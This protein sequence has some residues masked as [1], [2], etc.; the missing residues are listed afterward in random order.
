MADGKTQADFRAMLLGAKPKPEPVANAGAQTHEEAMAAAGGDAAK[1]TG[2]VLPKKLPA[3]AAAAQR[4]SEYG[5]RVKTNNR[6]LVETGEQKKARKEAKR[7]DADSFELL[8]GKEETLQRVAAFVSEQSRGA[9]DLRCA[10]A[11]DVVSISAH[12]QGFELTDSAE[13]LKWKLKLVVSESGIFSAEEVKSGVKHGD[14]SLVRAGYDGGFERK[15]MWEFYDQLKGE[16]CRTNRKW[17]RIQ[18]RGA[19]IAAGRGGGGAAAAAPAAS[20][21]A[22]G[23]AAPTAS[24][25]SVAAAAAEPIDLSQFDSEEQLLFKG[26]GAAA[27]KAELSRLGLKCGGAPAERAARCDPPYP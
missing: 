9:A 6:R 8:A 5:A 21:G 19:Q 20:G 17:R 27:L 2:L 1:I 25:G 23:G 24:A 15:P 13:G 26:P 16:V 18:Q 10:R 4:P 22:G 12:R 7:K 14:K 11:L 3:A